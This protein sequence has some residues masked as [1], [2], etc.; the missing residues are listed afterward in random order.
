MEEP[1]T[2]ARYRLTGELGRGGMGVVYRAEDPQLG[3]PV[4]IKVILFP[5]QA[6]DD[7]RAQLEQRFEREARSA[8]GIRH[9]GVVTVHDFG[10]DGDYLYLVME[11]VPGESLADKLKTGWLPERGEAFDVAAQVADALAAAHDAGVVHRDVTP[12]NILLAE[13]GRVVVTDFG[14]ARS[15]GEETFELTRTGMLVGSPSFMSPEQVRNRD[16]DGRADLFSLGV[17][18][19]RLLTGKLPF[20][21]QDLTSLLYQIVHEDPLESAEVRGRLGPGTVQFLRKCLAKAEEDR[22]QNAGELAREARRL[23]AAAQTAELEETVALGALASKNAGRGRPGR[24]RRGLLAL[25]LLAATIAGAWALSSMFTGG[26]SEPAAA[27][28]AARSSPETTPATAAPAVTQPRTADPTATVTGDEIKP[29]PRTAEDFPGLSEPEEP[30]ESVVQDKVLPAETGSAAGAAPAEST[31]LPRPETPPPP[32]A[33]RADTPPPPPLEPETET[34]S[35]PLETSTPAA[36]TVPPVLDIDDMPR[37]LTATEV[38]L[39][40]RVVDARSKVVLTVDGERVTVA[41]DGEFVA[42]RPLSPGRNALAFVAVDVAGNRT[43]K[44]IDVSP[45]VAESATTT[46]QPPTAGPGQRRRSRFVDRGDGTLADSLTGIVWTK[47]VEDAGTGWKESKVYCKKL[48]VGSRSDWTLPTI[49]EIEELFRSGIGVPDGVIWSSTRSGLAKAWAFDFSRGER[50]ALPFA[51]SEGTEIKAFCLRRQRRQ[52][53]DRLPRQGTD[54][55]GGGGDRN[56]G[57]GAQ[58][59]PP[60]RG[61]GAPPP[62]GQGG[63]GPGGGGGGGGGPGG[64]GGG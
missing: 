57:G 27:A 18:L 20:S 34:A 1:K 25:V 63:G 22:I 47:W 15:I 8:A 60:P 52:S 36:D 56:P 5:P 24:T 37:E 45:A 3:R 4:A 54:P 46:T 61:G 44:S 48:E 17:V 49:D 29:E 28:A 10:R 14:I 16:F 42:R 62:G 26:R 59:P 41:D 38:V 43:M 33:E 32:P 55:F 58:N 30:E 6:T 40:G 51:G 21:S 39:S 13:D 12:R 31:T 35:L 7:F 2:I 53:E 9:P 64:G 19:Y 23:R 50:S 11:L